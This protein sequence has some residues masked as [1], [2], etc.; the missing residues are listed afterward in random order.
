[1]CDL[2]LNPV[3]YILIVNII[4][5]IWG[6]RSWK[7][8]IREKWMNN[9]RDA[10]TDIIGAA[11][12]VYAESSNGASNL[13][14]KTISNFIAK[15]QKLLLL[16][17]HNKKEKNEFEGKSEALREAAESKD[18]EKYRNEVR[19]FSKSINDRVLNPCFR[20]L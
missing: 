20:W 2:F 10:G 18:T 15:E 9:L 17:A 11:E 16:F 19:Q 3:T 14:P 12:L 7:K 1:M 13:Q 4:T 6:V 8:N 5:L